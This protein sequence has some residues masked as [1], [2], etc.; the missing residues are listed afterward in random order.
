MID[1]QR[2]FL[3]IEL[4][5]FV[6]RS[7]DHSSFISSIK[8]MDSLHSP[9]LQEI[10]TESEYGN[11][12]DLSTEK[13]LDI[14][15]GKERSYLDLQDVREILLHRKMEGDPLLIESSSIPLQFYGLLMILLCIFGKLL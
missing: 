12:K 10:Y 5:S 3:S 8:Y 14:L 11:A 15:N 6:K 7:F 13:L 2:L 1:L 9:R 4:F